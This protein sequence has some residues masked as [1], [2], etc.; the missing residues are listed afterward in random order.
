MSSAHPPSLDA[1]LA[2][3]LVAHIATAGPTVLPIWFLWEDGA[4]WWLTG[5]W[6]GLAER[7]SS[8]PRVSIVVDSCDL[9]TGTV[10]SATARGRAEVVAMDRD[11]AVRKLAKYL[12]PD[13]SRWPQERFL[14]PLAD[15]TTRL[16]RLIPE[17]VPVLRDLSWTV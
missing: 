13:T 10:L 4:F 6:S 12:G 7:L 17:R 2:Q 14:A 1:L 9:T 5:S 3:P 16:A 15:P 11:R 8:D